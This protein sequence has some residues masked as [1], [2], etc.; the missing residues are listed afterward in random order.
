MA[1]IWPPPAGSSTSAFVSEGR[2]AVWAQRRRTTATPQH[3]SEPAAA[4][5]HPYSAPPHQ[6]SPGALANM[7]P[8]Q[9]VSAAPAAWASAE[10]STAALA[11][12]HHRLA[13]GT[14]TAPRPSGR[15][16]SRL[17]RA[18]GLPAAPFTLRQ[19]LALAWPLGSPELPSSAPAALN[20]PATPDP[21][22]PLMPASRSTD[23][24]AAGR[25]GSA[26]RS[27]PRSTPAVS[28]VKNTAAL[29]GDQTAE[30]T[31]CPAGAASPH[32]RNG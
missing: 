11:G 22:L 27:H 23:A 29:V 15:V 8:A 26:A 10:G 3:S 4:P 18:A 20:S 21:P 7:S 19:G 16:A 24:A 25:D 2:R 12:S 13:S 5:A 28:S 9:R 14:T 30:H 31:A 1:L 17:G 32:A 6:A